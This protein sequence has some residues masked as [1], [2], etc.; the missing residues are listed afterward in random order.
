MGKV[1]ILAPEIIS[2]IAAGEVIDR[3]AS[4]VKEL[5]ENSLDAGAKSIE[6]QL[7]QA[8]KLLIEVKDSGTGIEQDDTET[9]FSRHST[10]KITDESDLYSISSLGFRGEALYSI[11]SV[12]DITLRSKISS[13]DTGWEIHVRG[14]KK[15]GLRPVNMPRGT[16]IQV[17]ELFFNTPA[18][19]KFLKSD[20]TELH[21]ILNLFIPYTILFPQIRF[22]LA[23]NNRKIIDLAPEQDYNLRAARALN[24]DSGH[25]LSAHQDF[26]EENVSI[27]LILGDINIQ[28][29]KK[30]MQFIFINNRPVQNRN[31][32]FH[33]NNV[34]KLLFPEGT[35]PFFAAFIDLPP[36]SIDV[37]IHPTKREVK[38]KSEYML[39]SLLRPLC[40]MTLMSKGK[41]KQVQHIPE[42]TAEKIP[43][44][45][46]NRA[47]SPS[48]VSGR[49]VS[50]QYILHDLREDLLK[51]RQEDIFTVKQDNLRNV[52]TSSRYI[53]S[54]INKY[55]LFEAESSMLVIDQ[56]AAHERITYEQLKAQIEKGRI[57]AQQLLTP[58]LM[59]LSP[60]EMISWEEGKSKLEEL[61][62]SNTLWDNE[63]IAVHTYPLLIAK[64]EAAV[65]NLLSGESINR[66]DNDTLARR[67]C[68][69]SVMAGEGMSKEQAEY[70]RKQ[71][72]S[73]KD[74][75]TCPHGRPVII[76]IQEKVL[77]KQFLRK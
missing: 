14:N 64:P 73:C 7:K 21:Q 4:V 13:A 55:L 17:R 31:L 27:R 33:I 74:P 22:L 15:K 60:Q 77:E 32:N 1:H 5:L 50:K 57:Q 29:P 56:H 20:S 41:A 11:A 30:D 65:R 26:P 40:E 66:C 63:T 46:R 8:G 35:Y 51:Y 16:E 12:S 38:I 44:G 53:G 24:L 2:K 75:F 69:Q 58:L 6:I 72:L 62:F 19:R 67:A 52:L 71:L 28:R 3:P 18:R 59:K 47:A 68:R 36:E 37:N 9:I 39:L 45:K 49:P 76:E 54:F 34:Y 25:L 48:R 70:I 10:S 61:G 43:S 23:H 42:T